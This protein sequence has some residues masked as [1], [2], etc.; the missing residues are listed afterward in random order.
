LPL[1]F[2]CGRIIQDSEDVFTLNGTVGGVT[3]YLVQQ[4]QKMTDISTMF[5]TFYGNFLTIEFKTTGIMQDKKIISL[6]NDFISNCSTVVNVILPDSI[7]VIGNDFLV[8]DVHLTQI[9][10]PKKIQSVGKNFLAGCAQIAEL[11]L[12]TEITSV[13]ENFLF[14]CTSLSKLVITATAVLNISSYFLFDTP[15][16]DRYSEN[17]HIVVPTSIFSK[18][19]NDIN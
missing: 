1:T 3:M 11:Y 10:L 17:S 2:V 9:T 13:G 6:G 14:E 16:A 12:P 19:F 5:S 7:N 4:D 15:I 8:N 18:Y